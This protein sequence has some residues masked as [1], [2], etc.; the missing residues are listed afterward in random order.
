LHQDI[1]AAFWPFLFASGGW[2]L[3]WVLSFYRRGAEAPGIVA[4]WLLR[5]MAASF[6]LGIALLLGNGDIGLPNWAG[7]S[8]T[9]SRTWW[10]SILGLVMGSLLPLL[11]PKRLIQSGIQPKNQLERVTFVVVTTGML[12]GIPVAIV[13]TL[14]RENI[15][16]F[17]DAPNRTFLRHDTD[18]LHALSALMGA[19]FQS[20]RTSEPDATGSRD[21]AQVGN[22]TGTVK[23]LP[24]KLLPS[25]LSEQAT[26]LANSIERRNQAEKAFKKSDEYLSFWPGHY[27]GRA[28]RIAGTYLGDVSNSAAVYRQAKLEQNLNADELCETIDRS[29]LTS[30]ELFRYLADP[31]TK[32]KTNFADSAGNEAPVKPQ[33]KDFAKWFQSAMLDPAHVEPYQYKVLNRVLLEERYPTIFRSRSAI[34]RTVCIEADQWRRLFIFFAALGSFVFFGAWVDLNATSMHG[35]YLNRLARI[36]VVPKAGKS[37]SVPISELNTTDLGAPYHL[38][39]ASVGWFQ[40]QLSH[41]EAANSPANQ[42]SPPQVATPTRNRWLDLPEDDEP[43]ATWVDSFLFS[44]RYCGSQATGYLDTKAYEGSIRGE[45]NHIDLAEAVAVS[46]GAVSPGQVHNPFIAFLMFALNL[47]LGQWLPNPRRGKPR[48]RP[49]VLPLLAELREKPENRQ[50][51][52]VA[53]GGHCENL[54][55]IA[56]LR[57]RCRVVI[58]VDAGQDP[59]HCFD[60]LARVLR[61]ARVH[62]GIRILPLTSNGNEWVDGIQAESLRLT[63]DDRSLP[64]S[65]KHF[66]LARILY[67]DGMRG[68]LVYVKPSMDG[69]EPVELQ[70]YRMRNRS[71]PHEPTSDQFFDPAQVESYRQLGHH[72]GMQ[73]FKGL[74]TEFRDPVAGSETT[75]GDLGDALERLHLTSTTPPSRVTEHVAVQSEIGPS[76]SVTA[77]SNEEASVTFV[78][79]GHPR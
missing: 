55:M 7:D 16:G 14:G 58:A 4:R 44:K 61:D 71:F 32:V 74:A 40:R 49:S 57:R 18:D 13:G 63:Q 26:N 43:C 20:L 46:G 69:D 75:A 48:T 28:Y 52:F 3:A 45:L 2:L 56:L 21:A 1:Y 23:S 47:R 68:L 73:L 60:D 5:A 66:L 10:G 8:L 31:N 24:S 34:R 36:L 79:P 76:V 17:S 12:V 38:I 64:K 78:P 9:V 30:S 72:I 54:G 70:Q 65:N 35:Y 59:D 62:D 25:P 37:P 6:V 27:L 41:D 33:S 51:C 22:S 15:S 19:K 67:P 77:S 11:Q 50:Y 39:L 29:L 53:D 42:N